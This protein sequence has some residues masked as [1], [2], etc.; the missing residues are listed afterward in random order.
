MKL[1]EI[2]SNTVSPNEY[3]SRMTEKV[4]LKQIEG[5][6]RKSQRMCERFDS[7]NV[8]KVNY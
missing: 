7:D 4:I 6:L 1:K 3:R 8:R 5:D 2:R